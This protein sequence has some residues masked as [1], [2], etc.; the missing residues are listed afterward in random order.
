[1]KRNIGM[2]QIIL[3]VAI[4][5]LA[6]GRTSA[7]A[8]LNPSAPPA[9]QSMHRPLP[10]DLDASQVA[11]KTATALDASPRTLTEMTA[12]LPRGKVSDLRTKQCQRRHADRGRQR[13][14]PLHMVRLPYF[15]RRGSSAGMQ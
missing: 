13:I 1:M 6:M 14:D 15:L 4:I 9:P 7:F 8:Q 2:K 5:G 11:E 3:P 12:D 10:A